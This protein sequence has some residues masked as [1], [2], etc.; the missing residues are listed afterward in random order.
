MYISGTT[1]DTKVSFALG[2]ILVFIIEERFLIDANV[3]R[4][5]VEKSEGKKQ[6]ERE[7]RK[8]HNDE[9]PADRWK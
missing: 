5:L 4:S 8:L 3:F 1:R 2:L 6:E 9:M 7:K